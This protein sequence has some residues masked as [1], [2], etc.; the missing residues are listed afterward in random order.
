MRSAGDPVPRGLKK[1]VVTTNIVNLWGPSQV[2]GPQNR[3]RIP[4]QRNPGYAPAWKCNDICSE[5]AAI[6]PSR[7]RDQEVAWEQKEMFFR[8]KEMHKEAKFIGNVR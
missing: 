7:W 2:C 6:L 8:G 3:P 5:S 1:N 4:P